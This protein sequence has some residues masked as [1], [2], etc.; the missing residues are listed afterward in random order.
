MPPLDC[1]PP[2]DRHSL[3]LWHLGKAPGSQKFKCLL[4][5]C[6]SQMQS[7]AKRLHCIS[8]TL[9]ILLAIFVFLGRILKIKRTVSVFSSKYCSIK[10]KLVFPESHPP[11]SMHSAVHQCDS[12]EFSLLLFK[13]FNSLCLGLI[14]RVYNPYILQLALDYSGEEGRHGTNYLEVQQ[15]I[16][17]ANQAQYFN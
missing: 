7:T 11:L 15:L 9:I 17:N 13:N 1:E 8:L 14:S 2:K 5:K 10:I 16:N 3:Y 4:S 12:S 6:N